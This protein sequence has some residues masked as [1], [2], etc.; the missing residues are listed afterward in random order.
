M[1][2]DKVVVPSRGPRRVNRSKSSPAV[3]EAEQLTGRSQFTLDTKIFKR[4]IIHNIIHNNIIIMI[5]DSLD[6]VY[7]VA[8]HF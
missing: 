4:K 3:D 2:Y 8:D 5:E 1:S 7:T 6:P